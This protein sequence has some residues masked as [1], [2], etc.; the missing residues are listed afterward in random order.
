M[1]TELAG[2][3][4]AIRDPESR[5]LCLYVT[6]IGKAATIDGFA[7]IAHDG[8]KA[9]IMA[10]FC[11]G[12]DPSLQTGDLHVASSFHHRGEGNSIATDAKLSSAM[13]AS[14]RRRGLNVSNE[15]SATVNS[16]AGPVAKAELRRSASAA[17]VNMEDYWAASE[18]AAAGVPFASVRAVLD[19]ADQS[20]P[21]H[22]TTKDARPA[23]VA[24][25]AV[26]RP[27]RLLS[28]LS[29]AKQSNYARGN[30]THCVLDAIDALTLARPLM[31]ETLG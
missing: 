7:R 11:G 10:G 12:T 31:P 28:L 24:L 26:I 2:I 4:Q 19:T 22:L 8:P 27:V 3:R 21:K 23:R 15:P 16:I 1:A 6:G 29:L 13:L 30:L 5:G 14:A 25:N 9:V 18:A 20:L 17:S